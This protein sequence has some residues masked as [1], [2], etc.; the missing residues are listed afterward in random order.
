MKAALVADT[1]INSNGDDEI[2]ISEAEAIT[3]SL[4]GEGLEISDLTGIEAFINI[5][6]LNVRN[7]NLTTVDVSK[8]TKLTWLSIDQNQ[9]TSLDV[10]SLPSLEALYAGENKLSSMD[11]S[12]NLL[13]KKLWL[14]INELTAIDISS[15]TILEELELDWN[16]DL[17]SV[18]FTNNLQL[19][20]IHL[21]QTA[22]STIDVSKLIDL[23]RLYVSETNLTSINLSKNTKLYD[24]R[25]NSNTISSFDFSK[26]TE[27]E[28][29]DIRDCDVRNLD[30]SKNTK[31][32]Q[33][34]LDENVLTGIN[35]SKNPLLEELILSHNNIVN[36]DINKNQN[37]TKLML[38]D[39]SLERAYLKNGNNSAILEF[40]IKDNVNLTCITVDDVTFSTDN[41]IDKDETANYN[42]DCNAEWEVY[43]TD[44]NFEAA[45]DAIP[46]LDDDGDGVITYEEAQAFTGDLDLSGQNITSVAGLEAFTNAASI[47]ISGNSITDISSLLDANSVIVSSRVT[48]E[49]KTLARTTNNLKALNVANNLIVEI[50]ISQLSTI[51]ELNVSNNKLTYLN[52]NNSNNAAI[53]IFNATGNPDLGCIQVDNVADALANTN[54]TKDA[55]ASYSAFC[56]RALSVD[57]FLEDNISLYP[58]PTSTSFKIQLSNRL[59]LESIEIYNLVGKKVLRTKESLINVTDLSSGIYFIKIT[60]DKGEINKKLIK[61]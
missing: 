6:G 29:I 21:W 42:T 26:N 20:R 15:N 30:V 52:V 51:T 17:A 41:W 24:F 45:L 47:N 61:N 13:L 18:D 31:L 56:E 55:T 58:N 14:N 59:E 2:Q 27:L 36:I 48:G 3:Q 53:T 7:N 54:W 39:N 28:R 1:F 32:K 16:F 40:N 35:V 22:I 10:S 12:N 5:T 50:D 8:N 33:L 11:V 9:L 60:T 19:K 46:G 49:K 38:D 37:L 23:E 25:S 43:T 57:E 44:E 34:W 4:T